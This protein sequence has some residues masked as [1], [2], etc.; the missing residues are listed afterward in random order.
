MSSLEERVALIRKRVEQRK[1]LAARDKDDKDDWPERHSVKRKKK[2]KEK[3]KELF[4][5]DIRLWSVEQVSEHFRMCCADVSGESA[6]SF[7]CNCVRGLDILE[8]SK[9]ELAEDLGLAEC[10]LDIVWRRIGA[11]RQRALDADPDSASAIRAS[12]L[13]SR[14]DCI[15]GR[16]S[17]VLAVAACWSGDVVNSPNRS[18]GAR[19]NDGRKLS[20]N[21]RRRLPTIMNVKPIE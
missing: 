20:T 17:V 2:R 8:L 15:K 18:K 9:E 10:Q 19:Q 6:A 12:Q 3:E 16:L 7:A 5:V 11:L 21:R 1:C 14:V 13:Q 4:D